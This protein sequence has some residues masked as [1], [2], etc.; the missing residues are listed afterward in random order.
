MSS[1]VCKNSAYMKYFAIK[2]VGGCFAGK[3]YT[4]LEFYAFLNIYNTKIKI[5][6]AKK[7]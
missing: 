7:F 1:L 3:E 2:M 5:I 4:E 6:N